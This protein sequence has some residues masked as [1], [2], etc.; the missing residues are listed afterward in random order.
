MACIDYVAQSAIRGWRNHVQKP[1]GEPCAG[2]LHARF[3][4]GMGKRAR[5]TGTAPLTT[6]A[7]ASRHRVRPGLQHRFAPAEG[8]PRSRWDLRPPWTR[9]LPDLSDARRSLQTQTGDRALDLPNLE[10]GRAQAMLATVRSTRSPRR[11]SPSN[12]TPCSA[13]CGSIPFVKRRQATDSSNATRAFGFS[14]APAYTF[15][16][17]ASHQ[18]PPESPRIRKS[19]TVP[20]EAVAPEKTMGSA[21]TNVSMTGPMKRRSVSPGFPLHRGCAVDGPI[22]PCTLARHPATR[23]PAQILPS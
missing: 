23:A 5:A 11:R 4:R 17:A 18:S 13:S 10:L 14:A 6:N 8:D 12:V 2:K 1:I 9:A 3:E 22:V 16:P 20:A 7:S 15:Q 19:T 21:C